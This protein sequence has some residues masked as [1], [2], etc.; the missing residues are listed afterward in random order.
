MVGHGVFS[1]M[2]GVILG[3]KEVRTD[4][5][6]FWYYIIDGYNWYWLVS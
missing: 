6:F 5:E 4:A 2:S 3:R 1:G